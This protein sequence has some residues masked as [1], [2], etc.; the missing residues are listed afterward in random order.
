MKQETLANLKAMIK[1]QLQYC[2]EDNTPYVCQMAKED[3]DRFEGIIIE[4][5]R[6]GDTINQA[7]IDLENEYNPI[8]AND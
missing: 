1:A 5:V 8:R 4:R 3:Y 7:I 6:T 2:E